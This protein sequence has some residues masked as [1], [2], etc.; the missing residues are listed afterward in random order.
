MRLKCILIS[1][2]TEVILLLKLGGNEVVV[3]RQNAVIFV[4]GSVPLG[5]KCL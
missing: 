3:A 1:L 4:V 5:T 2:A